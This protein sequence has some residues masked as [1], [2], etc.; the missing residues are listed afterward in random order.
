MLT[1]NTAYKYGIPYNGPFVLTQCWTNVKVAL[2][3]GPN[4]IRY[5]I[6]RIKTYTSDTNVE[7]LNI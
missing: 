6:R 2:Q 3:C 1:N 7:D 4:K 5:N